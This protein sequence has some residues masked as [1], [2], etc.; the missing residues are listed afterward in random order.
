M[1]RRKLY[2]AAPL[3]V[4]VALAGCGS[5]SG[6][7]SSSDDSGAD[8]SAPLF[9]KVPEAYRDGIT[10]AF[11][12]SSPPLSMVDDAGDPAGEDIDLMAALSKQLGI[13]IKVE[14][15]SFENELLGLEQGKYDFV[16]QTNITAER[17]VKYDQ[18]AQ[19]VDGYTFATL[20][21]SAEVG[22]SIESLCGLTIASQ[23]GDQSSDYLA[24]KSDGCTAAGKEAITL[25]QLPSLSDSY[26]AVASGRADAAVEPKSV[27]AY[28]LSQP[29]Q[30]LGKKWKSTGPTIIP[31]FVGY[32]FM[33]DGDLIDVVQKGIQALMDDGTYGKI[34]GEYGLDDNA[35]DTASIDPEPLKLD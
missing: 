12:T 16:G 2:I 5:P 26:V 6:D 7:T 24:S 8:T 10:V 9:D 33:P 28:F 23:S 18:L 15:T 22:D 32:T 34:L 4:A 29:D 13:P 1:L 21:T 27:L 25:V 17:A 35:L 20:D 11:Q 14:L 31:N 3:A 30:Q 19:F